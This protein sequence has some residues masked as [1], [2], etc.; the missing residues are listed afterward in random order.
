MMAIAIDLLTVF[1]SPP[2]FRISASE[3][4]DFW[5]PVPLQTF[6]RGNALRYFTNPALCLDSRF[7]LKAGVAEVWRNNQQGND[8][9]SH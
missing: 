5:D 9:Y 6:F 7:S 3:L 1:V 8:G 4:G 2:D